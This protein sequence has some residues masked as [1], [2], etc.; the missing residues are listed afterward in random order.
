MFRITTVL[1][2]MA[3]TTSLMRISDQISRR[4]IGNGM[5]LVFVAG[6]VAG[7]SRTLGQAD[8]FALLTYAVLQIA[9]V[10]VV[11]RGYRRAIAPAGPG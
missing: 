9:I 2:L 4:Q 6:I 3:G 7:L 8:P 10:A 5:F 1:T 11:S